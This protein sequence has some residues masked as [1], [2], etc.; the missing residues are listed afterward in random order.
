[1]NSLSETTYQLGLLSKTCGDGKRRRGDSMSLK[2]SLS[3]VLRCV[4]AVMFV[5]AAPIAGNAQADQG[6]LPQTTRTASSISVAQSQ[7]YRI[8]AG[9]VLDI[10]ILN[11]PQL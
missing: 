6:A 4:L 10:R 2:P 7:R 1:M 3:L 5:I 8:G 9:D 11:R